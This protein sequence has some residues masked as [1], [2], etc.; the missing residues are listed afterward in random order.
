MDA[1]SG[2]TKPET[3]PGNSAA[4]SADS[5]AK[6]SALMRKHRIPAGGHVFWEGE[7]A[8]Y[9]YYLEHGHVKGMKTSA[10]GK[11]FTIY[12]YKQGDFFG[13]LGFDGEPSQSFSAVAQTDCVISF[14]PRGE[15]EFALWRF[16]GL[17]LECIGW[18]SQMNRHTQTKLRDLMLYGKPGALCSTLIR[19]ANTYG[20][21]VDD[22]ILITQRITNSELAETIGAA[23][24]SVNRLL[25]D[26]R[27]AGALSMRQGH[28]VVHDL[29]QLM[30]HCRCE[31]CPKEICRM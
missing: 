3:A 10:E 12:R 23:R 29:E 28:I 14:I 22:G 15:L 21:P 30:Q 20:M 4:F 7:P 31:G 18:M 19:M 6:L 1:A 27:R 26:Y 9:W 8:E 16:G 2:V 17:A 24:E 11:E 5:L 13:Q 25:A